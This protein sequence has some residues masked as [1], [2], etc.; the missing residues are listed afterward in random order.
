MYFLLCLL[1][2]IKAETQ[3]T[4][5]LFVKELSKE[6][7]RNEILKHILGIDSYSVAKELRTSDNPYPDYD[8]DKT[9]LRKIESDI[10]NRKH[11][12]RCQNNELRTSQHTNVMVFIKAE[13]LE[14]L[15]ES[16]INPVLFD[17]EI[18]KESLRNEILKHVLGIDS[19][20]VAKELR[21]SNN[22]YPDNDVDK[23][24][25]RKIESDFKNKNHDKRCQNNELR[26][27]QH[28]NVMGKQKGYERKAITD[29]T[30]HDILRQKTPARLKKK[31]PGYRPRPGRPKPW[32]RPPHSSEEDFMKLNSLL[33]LTQK[34]IF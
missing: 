9:V 8:V 14:I 34:F 31:K 25:L 12:K 23:T 1:V 24:V 17:R 15:R 11:D 16:E 21:T 26:T 4:P 30:R 18:S 22:P 7:L 28:T 6:S 20:S 27:S 5:V 13:T 33:Q 2:F 19:Y 32:F 3:K 29:K 10:K